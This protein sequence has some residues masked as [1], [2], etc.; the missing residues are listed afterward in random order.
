[1]FKGRKIKKLLEKYATAKTKKDELTIIAELEQIGKPAVQYII[2]ALKLRKL[3]REQAQALLG[4]LFDHLT[5]EQIIPLTGESSSDVRRIAKEIIIKKGKKSCS[6]LLLEHLDSSNFFLRTNTTELLARFK[7]QSIVPKLIGMFNSA[8]ADLK[9]NI[10]KILGSTDSLPAKKLLISALDDESWEVRLSAVKS[11][12]KMRDPESVQSLIERLTEQ[13]PQMKVLALDAL[14]AI[15]D[16][17]AVQ[18]MIKLLTDSDLLIRQKAT[19]YLIE[20]A[21]S[22]SVPEIIDL[23]KDKDVN[24]RRCAIEVLDSLKDPRTSI[25]LMNAIKDSDWWV[26]QIATD[27]L[28]K[29]KGE[30]I[31]NGF[32]AMAQDTDE[33]LRRCAVEFFNKTVHKSALKPLIELL[34]D[35]DWWVR[36]KAVT[37]LSKLKDP[38]AI[39]PLAEMIHDD[40]VKWAVPDALAEIGG[41]DVLEHLKEFVLDEEK[42]VRIEAIKA[43]GKLKA[44]DAIPVLKE[45]LEETDE[46]VITEAVSAIKKITGKTVKVKKKQILD[47]AAQLVSSRGGAVEGAILT[48][49]IVVLD[50][51]NSTA[52]AAKYGD[53]FALNLMKNLD[54]AVTQ[55]ARKERYQFIKNTGDGFL[56]TFSKT[57]NAV[58]FALRTMN[59]INKYN[60]KAD[61]TKRINLRFGINLGETRVKEKGDRLG[62]AINMAFRIEGVKPEGLIS[63]EN[64]MSQEEMPLENRI[65]ISENVDNEIQNMAGVKTKL[66]GFFELKGITGLHKVYELTS[67]N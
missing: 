41:D 17:R 63:I 4:P 13:E 42:R 44:K 52:I 9:S 11:L 35:E 53:N 38:R 21:D 40:D 6:E 19:E 67:A 33:S 32:I 47:P 30:N 50:L 2:E 14:G 62:I 24:T 45:C 10:I 59:N 54:R 7:D 61:N 28:T 64:G 49:A 65:L 15:G 55:I 26:R 3:N 66:V 43:F 27:S 57:V 46:D 48:E 12:I 5:I 39:S 23:L 60:A 25:A 1:M 20:I 29:L 56:L 18:P 58:Q 37:A 36:E 8:D 22:G 16:K 31:V 34:K 51:C